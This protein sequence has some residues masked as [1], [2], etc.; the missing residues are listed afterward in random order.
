MSGDSQSNKFKPSVDGNQM[1]YINILSY[2]ILLFPISEIECA[3]ELAWI[4][5]DDFVKNTYHQVVGASDHRFYLKDNFKVEKFTSSRSQGRGN[6]LNRIHNYLV[7]VLNQIILLP[8]IIIIVLDSDLY[9]NIEVKNEEVEDLESIMAFT[10]EY[11]IKNV[12]NEIEKHKMIMPIKARKYRY[13][14]VLWIIPPGHVNFT[15]RIIIKNCMQ[16]KEMRFTKLNNWNHNDLYLITEK[17]MGGYR[18]TSRGLCRYWTGI[19]EAVQAWEYGNNYKHNY[20][21]QKPQSRT[22]NQFNRSSSIFQKRR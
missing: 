7:E 3:Y 13:P 15:D 4:I 11:L 20:I 10:F 2:S 12:H 16:L 22:N 8:K 9:K 19:D 1:Q 21:L 6:I 17:P 5:G 18:F 14:S